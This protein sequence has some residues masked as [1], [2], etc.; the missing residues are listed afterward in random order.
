ME[1]CRL[2][3]TTI[4]I[5]LPNQP[6]DCQRAGG[7]YWS[8]QSLLDHND[9]GIQTITL[10]PRFLRS[11]HSR[12]QHSSHLCTETGL[13]ES[14]VPGRAV[15]CSTEKVEKCSRLGK[16]KWML[17]N[18]LSD[19]ALTKDPQYHLSHRRSILKKWSSQMQLLRNP[20]TQSWSPLRP[21]QRKSPSISSSETLLHLWRRQWGLCAI[22]KTPGVSVLECFS[23]GTI[24]RLQIC[25]VADNS[26]VLF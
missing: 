15:V 14:T 23:S 13:E 19:S 2:E 20:S 12:H 6:C 3:Q 9:R 8:A 4:S 21:G 5:S 25:Q 18:R 22:W 26:V 10:Q 7:V 1:Q 17:S 16:Y 24:L 11:S